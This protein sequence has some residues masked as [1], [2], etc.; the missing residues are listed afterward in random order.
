MLHGGLI[1]FLA[2]NAA[3]SAL[4][5][6]LVIGAAAAYLKLEFLGTTL[7]SDYDT[8]V[9]TAQYLLGEPVDASTISVAGR[10]LKPLYPAFLASLHTMLDFHTAALLQSIFF[11]LFFIVAMFLL[12]QEYFEDVF[13]A[14]L[15]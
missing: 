9:L 2:R 11:F 1:S 5:V 4:L 10:M 3:L 15:A 7:S 13:P 6:L 14:V 8:Y 12:A